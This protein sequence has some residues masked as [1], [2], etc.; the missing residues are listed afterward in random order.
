MGSEDPGEEAKDMNILKRFFNWVQ[1]APADFCYVSGEWLFPDREA[2]EVSPD[3]VPRPA[4]VVVAA[5][6]AAPVA[7][8][9]PLPATQSRVRLQE[10]ASNRKQSK[11]VRDEQPVEAE[12]VGDLVHK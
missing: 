7:A 12:N 8:F 9:V 2:K 6:V 4:P 10:D 11:P 5:R 3:A 1:D